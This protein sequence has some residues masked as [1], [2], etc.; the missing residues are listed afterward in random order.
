MLCLQARGRGLRAFAH[1]LTA[2]QMVMTVSL[3]PLSL[4]FFGEA[5]LVGA[6]SNLLAVPVISFVIV[7]CAL[8]G[9]L[10]MAVCPPLAGPVLWLAAQL[11]HAQWWL[12]EKMASWPGAHWYLPTVQP[13]ALLLAVLGALWLF[14]PRGV[15]LRW[16]GA[17]LFLPLLMP[18]R[19]LPLEG[20]FQ[21]WVL[22]VGQGLSVVLRTREHVLVYDTG[23]RYPSGFDLGESTV[24]P[25]MRALGMNRLDM[26]MISHGDNDHAGGAQSVADA[27]PDAPRY[28]GEPDR[29]TL[30][31]QPCVA[32]QSW[33]WDGVRF[34]VLNPAF[35]QAGVARASLDNDKKSAK[36]NDRS[37]VLLVE[38]RGGRLLLT[39]DISVK[40]EPQVLAAMDRGV[41][42]VMLVPHHGSSGS[43][44][45]GFI[46][47]IEPSLAIVSAGWRNRFGHPRPDTLAR[48][49]AASVPVFNT[50]EQ[51]AIPLEFP[52]DSPAQRRQGWRFRET[53]YWRE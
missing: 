25:S 12:L 45:K 40:E 26:L 52:A 39:G 36:N 38:G 7:P 17:L 19:E 1:E 23:A 35:D 8:I 49:A 41:P 5:S 22:D 31:M 20:A 29:M 2:G 51:G 18:P 11:A 16:I 13:C 32:G 28:A 48:Y 6:L 30:P 47:G 27:F 4:W 44:S 37:C 3:L 53:R 14:L 15:P 9:V 50:A 33:Q 43:S 46:A 42:P 24:L 21:A 10:A 34:R